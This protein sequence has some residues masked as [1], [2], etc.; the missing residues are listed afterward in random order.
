MIQPQ[1]TSNFSG[2]VGLNLALG[3]GSISCCNLRKW[4][5][6]LVTFM[7][8]AGARFHKNW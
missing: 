4:M 7:L 8:L 6:E 5:L 3:L 1:S 2:K